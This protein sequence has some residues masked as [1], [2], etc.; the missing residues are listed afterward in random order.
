MHHHH[1][2]PECEYREKMEYGFN[3]VDGVNYYTMLKEIKSCCAIKVTLIS[4]RADHIVFEYNGK[5]YEKSY[6]DFMTS[7]WRD[8]DSF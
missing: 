8:Y 2:C 4:H 6:K 1:Y 3:L 7:S 5:Q